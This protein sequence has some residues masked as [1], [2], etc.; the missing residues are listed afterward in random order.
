MLLPFWHT[1]IR[2]QSMRHTASRSYVQL[3]ERLFWWRFGHDDIY[4]RHMDHG[5]S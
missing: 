5:V 3:H 2:L 4:W 1:S